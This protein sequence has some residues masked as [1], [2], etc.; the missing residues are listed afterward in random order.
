MTC[1]AY[2]QFSETTEYDVA[3]LDIDLPDMDGLT[4]AKKLI[5]SC[6]AINIIFITGY[7]EYALEAHELF[8]SAF[9]TKPVSSRK[10]RKAFENLRRP[11]LDLPDGFLEEHYSG[12]RTGGTEPGF[13]AGAYVLLLISL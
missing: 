3:L 8:C 1:P 6:P 5:A 10:R 13:Q 7:K 9:L 12:Q 11:F 4:L 2:K